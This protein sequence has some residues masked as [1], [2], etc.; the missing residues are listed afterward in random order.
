MPHPSQVYVAFS[1]EIVPETYSIKTPDQ[2][3]DV[4]PA[5]MAKETLNGTGS[6]YAV[7]NGAEGTLFTNVWEGEVP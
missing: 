3:A 7:V 6:E 1:P 5:G 2:F 4:I